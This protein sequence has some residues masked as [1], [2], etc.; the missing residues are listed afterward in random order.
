[1]ARLGSS[2]GRIVEYAELQLK[3]W[4]PM[5]LANLRRTSMP[6]PWEGEAKHLDGSGI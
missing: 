1:L 2:P 6:P 4:M 5:P 3:C